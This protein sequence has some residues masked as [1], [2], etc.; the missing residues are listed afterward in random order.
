M[1]TLLSLI[2]LTLLHSIGIAQ[3]KEPIYTYYCLDS[4][5][6][7]AGLEMKGSKLFEG[8]KNEDLR[9]FL[10]EIKS[11]LRTYNANAFLLTHFATDSLKKISLELSFY[12]LDDSQLMELDS[13]RASHTVLV[14]SDEWTSDKIYRFSI[15]GM[16][17]VM[18]SGEYME[19][20]IPDNESLR[21]GRGKGLGS[22][23]NVRWEENQMPVYLYLGTPPVSFGVGGGGMSVGSTPLTPI[24]A[25]IGRL[26]Q[27]LLQPWK[28]AAKKNSG[29]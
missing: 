27:Q 10:P 12:R 18:R 4:L 1:K 22:S 24:D 8:R 5:A 28:P 2:L 3:E 19:L 25:A 26:Y 15:N 14:L 11:S 16:D 21:I 17:H 29:N 20:L 23:N 13:L 7:T 6:Q 9:S